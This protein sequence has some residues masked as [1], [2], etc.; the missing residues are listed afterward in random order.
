MKAACLA[1]L[2]L[3]ALAAA[4][5]SLDPVVRETDHLRVIADRRL[6][7]RLDSLAA[8]SEG[9]WSRLVRITGHIPTSRITLVLHDEDDYSNGWAFAPSAWVNAWLT[10]LQFE[11]RGGTDWER[12]LIAHEMGHVFTLRALGYDGKLVSVSGTGQRTRTRDSQQGSLSLSFNRCEAWLAEGMAQLAAEQCGAD[13]WDGH[14]DMLERVA[15]KHGT[16]LRD[17]TQRTFWSDGRTSEQTYNQGYSF[18]RFVTTRGAFDFRALLQAGKRTSLR[19][20][21]EQSFG[22]PFAQ[23]LE[24]WEKDVAARQEVALLPELGGEPLLA[25]APAAPW[26]VQGSPVGNGD[27]RWFLSSHTN[28]YAQLS[29]WEAA[30]SGTRHL[31]HDLEGRLHLSSDGNRLLAVRRDLF[32]D[33]AVINDLWELDTRTGLWTA[34]TSQ[35]RIADGTW[36]RDGLALIRRE[37]GHNLIELRDA[38][39][40]IRLLPSPDGHPVQ[41]ESSPEGRLWTVTMG[42][43]GY[44]LHEWNGSLWTPI[45][46]DREV[47]DPVWRDGSLWVS[48][49]DG[50]HWCAARLKDDSLSILARATGGV[51]S[52][53]PLGNSLLV[54]EYRQEGV[55]VK[56]LPMPAAQSASAPDT[57]SA[58]VPVQ[59]A[60]LEV[61]KGIRDL[62]FSPPQPM[63]WGA[64]VG[65]S[66]TVDTIGRFQVGDLWLLGA[67]LLLGE[68]RDENQ[69][70]VDATLLTHSTGKGGVGHAVSLGWTSTTFPPALSLQAWIQEIP[71]EIRRPA[72]D[73]DDFFNADTLPVV[74]SHGASAEI[75]Q[76]FSLTSFGY[77]TWQY[78]ASGIGTSRSG[79]A[80]LTLMETHLLGAGLGWQ[81]F[82]PG[83][84]G[85]WEGASLQVFGGRVLSRPN[86]L[87]GEGIDSWT[88]QGSLRLATNLRRRVLLDWS[89]EGAWFEPDRLL[90]GQGRASTSL[91]VGI[92]LPVEP[93]RLLSLGSRKL[94]LTQ[95]LLSFGP[96]LSLAPRSSLAESLRPESRHSATPL[97]RMELEPQ[98]LS[99]PLPPSIR[100]TGST[101]LSLSATALTFANLSGLWSVGASMPW[102]NPS[103]KTLRWHASIAL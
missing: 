2:L 70:G 90:A 58:I 66:S 95:P 81:R 39:G 56:T 84:Y 3:P 57:A 13:R 25:P 46:A 64:M 4:G 16:L 40:A 77:A 82:E 35:A 79:G 42:S 44:R 38:K 23:I 88:A 67:G 14:R 80:S 50:R 75:F 1:G 28:D 61:G 100:P 91:D 41:I 22:K 74:T 31:A 102:E 98:G 15:W 24:A 78:Q 8:L 27:R 30:P 89:T 26:S 11:L 59:A 33:R 20:A 76:R 52:P 48:A 54:S 29:L 62:P 36:Y 93:M 37:G 94:F 83:V 12:N 18:L 19:E 7:P 32:A 53:F 5:P 86:W 68:A 17:G 45:Q 63:A 65:Y 9:I 55:L 21:C 34:R 6:A 43:T 71:L 92:P 72:T 97:Q 47:K 60:T 10:P 87:L 99:T 49:R 73:S 101:D 69:I 96:R 103:L 51:F 85:P